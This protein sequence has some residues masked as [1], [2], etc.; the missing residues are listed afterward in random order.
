M[1]MPEPMQVYE[2]LREPFDSSDEAKDAHSFSA[3]KQDDRPLFDDFDIES[4]IE[5]YKR[6]AS[7][8]DQNADC[9]DIF[10]LD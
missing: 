3:L 1:Y 5:G 7:Q 6:T 9:D 8:R 2:D 10:K 4:M